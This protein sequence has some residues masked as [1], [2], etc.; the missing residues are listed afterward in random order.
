MG[1][2]RLDPKILELD[3]DPVPPDEMGNFVMIISIQQYQ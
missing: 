2:T 3:A 1:Q